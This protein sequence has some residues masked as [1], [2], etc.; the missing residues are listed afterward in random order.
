[1]GIED[2]REAIGGG[3]GA[4]QAE[5]EDDRLPALHVGEHLAAPQALVGRRPALELGELDRAADEGEGVLAD[6][7]GAQLLVGDRAGAR[8][9][10][11]QGLDT[12]PGVEGP[13]GGAARGEQGGRHGQL[14]V[15][16]LGL[17]D[18]AQGA[19]ELTGGLDVRGQGRLAEI[20]AG[21][22][23]QPLVIGQQQLGEP[24]GRD[25]LPAAVGEAAGDQGGVGP[26]LLELDAEDGAQREGERWAEAVTVPEVLEREGEA[27][28]GAIRRGRLAEVDQ[29]DRAVREQ[30]L[31]RVTREGG[32]IEGPVEDEGDGRAGTKALDQ[33]RGHHHEA[34][35]RR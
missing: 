20:G 28:G 26:A 30:G 23:P 19:V 14:G 9:R 12:R 3:R 2:H 18:L 24:R 17:E 4:R 27:R 31:L 32:Q 8:C 21:E 5:V 25:G 10:C 11:G 34:E 33:V 35:D 16:P 15:Q 13:L 29:G 1:V 22:L 6:V 7:Q